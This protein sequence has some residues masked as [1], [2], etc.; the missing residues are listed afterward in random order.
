MALPAEW[1]PAPSTQ[2]LEV[3]MMETA[4]SRTAGVLTMALELP[5]ARRQ[6][7][8]ADSPAGA[9]R[10]IGCVS[11]RQI[12]QLGS[13]EQP[14]EAVRRA[15]ELKERPGAAAHPA[16]RP[17]EERSA[18]RRKKITKSRPQTRKASE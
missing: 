13:G 12:K 8:A 18:V 17:V 11:N 7:L 14:D 10:D 9:P 1:Q 15:A 6:A 2:P 3:A 4:A 5:V 16:L